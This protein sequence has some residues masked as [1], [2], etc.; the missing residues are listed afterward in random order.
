MLVGQNWPTPMSKTNWEDPNIRE[1]ITNHRGVSLWSS[2]NLSNKM[3][4]NLD[5]PIQVSHQIQEISFNK[6]WLYK[7]HMERRLISNSKKTSY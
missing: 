4:K 6:P 3:E 1:D 7:K 2:T 5:S